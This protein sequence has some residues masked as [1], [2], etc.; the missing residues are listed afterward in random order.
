[1]PISLRTALMPPSYSTS[2]D[3]MAEMRIR[4]E[5]AGSVWKIEVAVGDSVA[6][7]DPLIVLEAMKM[8]IPLLAPRSGIVREIL[9]A[10]G[11]PI[12][13]GD[14]AVILGLRG[15]VPSEGGIPI[16]VGGKIIGAIGTSGGTAPQDGVVATA[17]V[18][19]LGQ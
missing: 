8:E 9:V 5:I 11:E 1:M 18:K 2:E 17:G 7:D 19:A 12:A 3:M 14:I 13:E 15:L 16:I 6:E 10:E 4:S